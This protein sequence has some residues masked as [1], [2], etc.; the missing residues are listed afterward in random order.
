MC[1]VSSV[2]HSNKLRPVTLQLK[3]K[4]QFQFA[5]YYAA[6]EKGYYKAAGFDVT[7]RELGDNETPFDAVFNGKAEFGTSTTDIILAR[8]EGKK[9][10]VLATIFQHSPHIIVSLKDSGLRYAQEL[11]GKRIAIEPGAAELYAFLI[12][13][14]VPL[15]KMNI[16]DFD[17]NYDK[18][19]GGEVDA[20]SAYS[21]D[22]PYTLAQA[23][24][25]I[26]IMSPSSAGID[27]Y[28]DL[29]FTTEEMI[30]DN[31]AVVQKFREASIK[32]WAYAMNN[33]EEIISLIYDKYSTRHTK[34]HLR[35]EAE[36]MQRLVLPFVVEIGY[37]NPGR[38]Q[39]ILDS[40]KMLDRVNQSLTIDGLL[41]ADY[42]KQDFKM[43]WKLILL[44]SGAFLLVLSFLAFY[45]YSSKN[46]KKEIKKREI[47]Q[48]ILAT[49]EAEI[50]SANAEL[51]KA[52]AEKDKFFSI[53][54][55]DLRS[56]FSSFLGLT[57][58]LSEKV[59]SMSLDEVQKLV[60]LMNKS[61][62]NLFRLLENLLEWSRLEQGLLIPQPG[63]YL[64]N[65][66]I[67]DTVSTIRDSASVKN[68]T[69]EINLA[70]DYQ[71]FADSKMTET[72]LRNLL[73]N[74]VKFTPKGGKITVSTSKIDDFTIEV[75]VE[76]TGIGM[77][78]AMLD[79]L[80]KLNVKINRKGTEGE[81]STG[82]GLLLCKEFVEANGGVLKVSSI[83]GKGSRFSFTISQTTTSI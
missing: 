13:E 11:K 10:V 21:T 17:F 5:G 47:I 49:S 55:H 79:N 80:F 83:E 4:H 61:A 42:I 62:V 67:N 30:K 57:E 63:N 35:F 32:G 7:L 24:H 34:E 6:I 19:T 36:Q 53:I 81:L 75:S 20:I 18:L 26:H 23:G 33:S 28:G 29:L 74:A 39:T 66:L 44:I 41:Y 31:P 9:A 2:L 52:N 22:E 78:Q 69:I 58:I 65:Y 16:E 70:K 37:T 14:G 59:D 15:N 43:P 8:A 1:L 27:Y 38:W 46:L 82:L 56:P 72:V 60:N 51:I 76:D 25:E 40:Y 73:S 54:S 12:A 45:Y 77:N 64:I 48:Q 50:K 71:V 3:W 68:Q